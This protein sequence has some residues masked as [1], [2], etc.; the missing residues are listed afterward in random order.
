MSRQH[1]ASGVIAVV[2]AC[3]TGLILFGCGIVQVSRNT[4]YFA[5]D[6]EAGQTIQL[7]R[8]DEV[9]LNLVIANGRDWTAFSGDVGVAR[10]ATTEVVAFAN[11]EKARFF[12]FT[13][14]GRGHVQLVACPATS[15]TCST[16]SPGTLTFDVNV[17]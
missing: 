13:L 6:R 17:T 14:V 10:P 15:G 16:S 11:G 4:R 3:A 12:D 2:A 7:H 8:G 5:T 1:A 9:T